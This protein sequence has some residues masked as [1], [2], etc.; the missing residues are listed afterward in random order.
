MDYLDSLSSDNSLL[1]QAGWRQQEYQ[2]RL[3]VWII[4]ILASLAFLRYLFNAEGNDLVKAPI[5]GPKNRFWARCKFF[6]DASSV[7]DGYNQV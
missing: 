7:Q 5:V 1:L 2:S 3:F 6:F 4:P